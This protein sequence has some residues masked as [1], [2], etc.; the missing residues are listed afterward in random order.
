MDELLSRYH[1]N[2]STMNPIELAATFQRKMVTIHPFANGNGR[3]TR[4]IMD[5]ILQLHGLPPAAGLATT[6]E[7]SLT[8][9]QWVKVVYDAVART[10]M[11]YKN[12]IILGKDYFVTDAPLPDL[13][14]Y[15][16]DMDSPADQ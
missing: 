1:A 5:Y 2:E 4:L 8:N 13:G 9:A 12:G 3:T 10:S 14:H 6:N 11:T 16:D 7:M 15:L